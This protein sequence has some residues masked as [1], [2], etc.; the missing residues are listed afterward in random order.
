MFLQSLIKC[1]VLCGVPASGWQEL[2]R[3]WSGKRE[4]RGGKRGEAKEGGSRISPETSA[5][6]SQVKPN[7]YPRQFLVGYWHFVRAFLKNRIAYERFWNVHSLKLNF[8]ASEL[9]H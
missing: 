3:S 5:G 4:M 1:L 7:K 6:S 8:T 9:Y 2:S